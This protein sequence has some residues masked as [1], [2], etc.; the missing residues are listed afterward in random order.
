MKL[1]RIAMREVDAGKITYE[2]P[3]DGDG[4]AKAN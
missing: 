2:V 1:E 4:P 3:A